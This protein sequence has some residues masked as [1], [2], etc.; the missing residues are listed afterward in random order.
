MSALKISELFF[1]NVVCIL[2]LLESSSKPDI[3]VQSSHWL[4]IAVTDFHFCPLERF[5]AFVSGELGTTVLH[6]KFCVMT[7]ELKQFPEKL[8]E[9]FS[10]IQFGSNHDIGRDH[11]PP[12]Q[13][14]VSLRQ[15]HPLLGGIPQ[16][17]VLAY[18]TCVIKPC[19]VTQIQEKN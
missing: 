11:G 13:I 9:E 7:T 12:L 10:E 4:K 14:Q 16:I 19:F 6:L 2:F 15:T 3:L 17:D 5:D 18:P 1:P 8:Q